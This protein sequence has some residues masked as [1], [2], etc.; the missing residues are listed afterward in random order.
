MGRSAIT[1]CSPS[2]NP[3]SSDRIFTQQ[4]ALKVP[5]EGKLA[6][7]ELRDFC[8]FVN[9]L[10]GNL[11]DALAPL[12][13][14]ESLAVQR[15][16]FKRYAGKIGYPGD[17]GLAFDS[18]DKQGLGVITLSDLRTQL[19]EAMSTN[20]KSSSSRKG[21]K[22][23]GSKAE[24][25]PSKEGIDGGTSFA[26]AG[27]RSDGDESPERTKLLSAEESTREPT[28]EG[29]ER[30]VT[31]RDRVSMRE[32]ELAGAGEPV[33]AAGARKGSKGPAAR[34]G[35]KPKRRI[36][37]EAVQKSPHASDGETADPAIDPITAAS[38]L[39]VPPQ[40]GE[41]EGTDLSGRAP[42]PVGSKPPSIR[43]A[44]APEMSEIA[45]ARG[46]NGFVMVRPHPY[47]IVDDDEDD[48]VRSFV[49]KN[50]LFEVPL[51]PL[52]EL[53]EDKKGPPLAKDASWAVVKTN[54]KD[55]R[56]PSK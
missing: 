15:E 1:C 23:K 43:A 40:R 32:I 47:Q 4:R 48:K 3:H 56:K 21:S 22:T 29:G 44:V 27:A 52:Y 37:K 34:K 14:D 19:A 35:S 13:D 16:A 33:A 8:S 9:G 11:V 28:E 5:S 45:T 53:D 7:P 55:S 54:S 24:K 6:N 49:W 10:Y 41:R 18:M 31:L 2:C 39:A 17:A 26:S 12:G 36:S 51:I 30:G 50:I 42:S 38:L 46:E 25:R 20:S